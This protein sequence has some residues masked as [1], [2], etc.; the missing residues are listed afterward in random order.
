MAPLDVIG[1]AYTTL[2]QKGPRRVSPHFIPRILPNMAAGHVSIRFGLRGPLLAPSTA[3][4]TGAH[5]VGDAFR[6]IKHG[7]VT[8][9]VAGGTEAAINPLAIAG[10][11]QA[12]ALSSDFND[13]PEQSSR[14]FDSKR[15]GF[16][17]GEG[18]GVLVLEQRKAK[19][20]AEIVGYGCSA[21]A[22]HITSSHPDGSGAESAMKRALIEAQLAPRD[23]QHVNA[24]ATATP[25]GDLAELCALQRLFSNVTVTANK[26]SIGHLLGAA[27]AVESVLTILSLHHSLIP[28]T[29]NYQGG[30][31]MGGVTIVTGHSQLAPNLRAALCN[32]FGFGGTNASLCFTTIKHPSY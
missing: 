1:E 25:I 23:V 29:L 14:P 9:M 22:H 18:A 19:I 3:C 5:A 21:D 8:V 17:I 6:L 13:N 4:A 12:K 24:H 16:V 32:S 30:S 26:G 15:D 7:Y 2:A 20:Y 28:P 10:F 27:G 11:A 31:N